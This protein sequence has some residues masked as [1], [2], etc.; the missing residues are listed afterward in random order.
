M[1]NIRSGARRWTASAVLAGVLALTA[2]ACGGLNENGNA[3]GGNTATT[4]GGGG[5]AKNVT[6]RL[7]SNDF[8]EQLILGEIYKQS[9]EKA[10]YKV[11]YK[12]G[13]GSREIVAPALESGKIDM[14]VEYAGSALAILA[15]KEGVKDPQQIYSDLKAFYATKQI[16]PLDLAPMSDQNAFTVTQ[17]T[18]SKNNLKSLADVAKVA[19]QLT[20]GGPPECEQRVTCFKGVEQTYGAKF[21]GFKPIAQGALKYA[22]LTKGDIQV[23]LSFTTDGIIAKDNL[24]V[25]EDPK[26]V[27]PPDQAVPV[28]RDDFLAKAGDDFKATVNKVSAKITTEEI[29]KLNAKVDLDKEDPADVAKEWLSGQGL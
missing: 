29:T 10:G 5:A 8:S 6:V 28:V 25:L 9:L 2:A 18:S 12:S 27:F 19:P 16:T 11:D 7:A 24:V 20:V 13:L 15:K 17:E 4:A 1:G 14:Y 22:A 3:G 26:G 21:K 23:A